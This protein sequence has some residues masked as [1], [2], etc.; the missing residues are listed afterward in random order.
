[1]SG[2]AR[3]AVGFQVS[4]CVCVRSVSGG[5][6]GDGKVSRFLSIAGQRV[7]LFQD[8]LDYTTVKMAVWTLPP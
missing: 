4:V 6:R 1:M 5:R 3:G 7:F 8:G 2:H